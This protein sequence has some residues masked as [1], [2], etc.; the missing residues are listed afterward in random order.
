MTDLQRA[1][2]LFII[3]SVK[4]DSCCK[5]YGALGI[6]TDFLET[7]V[8]NAK[9]SKFANIIQKTILFTSLPF[10]HAIVMDNMETF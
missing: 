5:M 4:P 10:S 9:I 3:I 1:D 6:V 7:T 2:S 8:T